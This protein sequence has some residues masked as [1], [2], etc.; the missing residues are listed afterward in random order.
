MVQLQITVEAPVGHIEK[1]LDR[2]TAACECQ[3]EIDLVQG[4]IGQYTTDI[5][6]R[7]GGELIRQRLIKDE[8]LKIGCRQ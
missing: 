1:P 7:S 2:I 8:S 3:V 6:A 5:H 4:G